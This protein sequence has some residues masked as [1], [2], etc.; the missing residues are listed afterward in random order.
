M[1]REVKAYACIY[2]CGRRVQ[3]S[4]KAMEKH[5][6][7]CAMN[8]ARRACKICK[9][10]RLGRLPADHPAHIETEPMCALGA[11]PYGHLMRFD[12]PSWESA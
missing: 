3:T 8:P 10:K 4:R 5:E 12:C 7:T 11:L 2:T 6:Q 1:P 9:H